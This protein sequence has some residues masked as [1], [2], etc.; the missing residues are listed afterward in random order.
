MEDE[1]ADAILREAISTVVIAQTGAYIPAPWRPS[2]ALVEAWLLLVCDIDAIVNRA[3]LEE[4]GQKS[5]HARGARSGTWRFGKLR[6]LPFATS[7][8]TL[9]VNCATSRADTGI[10]FIHIHH[11][12][13]AL[14]A[15]GLLFRDL[16]R[17]HWTVTGLRRVDI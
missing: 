3:F 4:R 5:W 14:L 1:G 9:H 11:V 7:L 6:E 2:V 12:S 16:A 17:E 10:H 8:A 15:H 13:P